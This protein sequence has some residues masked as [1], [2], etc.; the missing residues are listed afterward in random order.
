MASL[1]EGRREMAEV[2]CR[3]VSVV[4]EATRG[5]ATTSSS[6]RWKTSRKSGQRRRP[7]RRE[8]AWRMT[9]YTSSASSSIPSHSRPPHSSAQPKTPSLSVSK[10]R[11]ASR[12]RSPLRLTREAT[13]VMMARN[14]YSCVS[15]SRARHTPIGVL[16]QSTCSRRRHDRICSNHLMRTRDGGSSYGSRR[17]RARRRTAASSSSTPTTPSSSRSVCRAV[18][19][20]SHGASWYP[21]DVSSSS[22]W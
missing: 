17:V 5:A 7:S 9:A 20:C 11:K 3:E 10:R 19:I 14:S 12:R 15:L 16:R 8:Q 22:P 13:E 1:W 21:V 4:V 2:R 6:A 18:S